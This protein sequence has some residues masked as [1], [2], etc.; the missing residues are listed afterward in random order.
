[1]RRM[2]GA[3]VCAAAVVAAVGGAAPGAGAADGPR[4]G[5][6]YHG[7]AGLSAGRVDL[8]FT[9]RNDGPTTAAESV[10][11][12]R[13][14]EPLAG[15]QELPEACARAGERL[16]TCRVGA[17]GGYRAGE[18]IAMRVRLRGAP[19]EVSLEFETAGSGAAV[20]GDRQ[21]VLVLDTGD[22]YAF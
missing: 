21:R 4:A 15:R 17:L 11:R 22:T 12:L 1:M 7:W 9:P 5:L 8:R 13:W 2:R 6:A 10:V 19:T 3:G 20:D 14:S 16:L 18:R